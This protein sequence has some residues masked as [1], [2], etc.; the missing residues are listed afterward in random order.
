MKVKQA[1]KKLAK[2]LDLDDFDAKFIELKAELYQK[3]SEAI[4]ESEQSHDEIAK[5]LGTSR[6]RITRI[7]NMGEESLSLEMLSRVIYL[8]KEKMPI[9]VA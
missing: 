4:L 5:L 7:A 6:T 1:T 3:A 8:L 9:K 2:D